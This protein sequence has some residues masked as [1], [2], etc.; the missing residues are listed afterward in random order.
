MPWNYAGTESAGTPANLPSNAVDWVLLELRHAV[1]T[2]VVWQKAAIL[3]NDG[4]IQDA[5]NPIPG[6]VR[7]ESSQTGDLVPANQSYYLIVRHRNHLAVASNVP[8]PITG[9]LMTCNFTLQPG[10]VMGSNQLA[11]VGGQY[12]MKAGDVFADGVIHYADYNT[13]ATNPNMSNQYHRNDCNLDGNVNIT[14]FEVLAPNI[15]SIGVNMVR[16]VDSF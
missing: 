5:A 9:N 13:Y 14:D 15:S 11:P 10:Q 7:L 3:L 4:S 6:R 16:Y 1:T 8:L 12:A 2:A